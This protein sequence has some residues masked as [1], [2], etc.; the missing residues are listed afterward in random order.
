VKRALVV[1]AALVSMATCSS[2]G[3]AQ[4]TR[5]DSSVPPVSLGELPSAVAAVTAA[6]TAANDGA[7]E[8]T[9]IN[10]QPGLVNLF[11]AV[12]TD[13]ELA[14]VWQDGSL[15][16]PG[17]PT[18]RIEGAVPFGL[19]GVDLGAADTFDDLLA[20]QVPD[21]EL[22]LLTLST[23][24]LDEAPTWAATLRSAKGGGMDVILTTDGTILGVVPR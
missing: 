5:A 4:G 15:Q 2:N 11:V 14:Y 7:V 12:G 21:A 13:D 9:E 20:E 3:E 6:V 10:V 8:Y 18:Q 24:A 19:D 17:E 16:Q 23:A 1:G 22:L